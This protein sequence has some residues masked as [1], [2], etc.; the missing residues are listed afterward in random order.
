MGGNNS[1]M[2]NSIKVAQK[3]VN[4]SMVEVTTQ[5]TTEAKVVTSQHGDINITAFD[6]CSVNGIT[7]NQSIAGKS[8]LQAIFDKSGQT[9]ANFANDLKNKIQQN[10]EQEGDDPVTSAFNSFFGGGNK[11]IAQ[12]SDITNFVSNILQ[13]SFNTINSTSSTVSI[14]QNNAINIFC[15]DASKVENVEINNNSE[16]DV[17]VMATFSEK[18]INSS[19]FKNILQNELDQ[20]SE[21]KNF[22]STILPYIVMLAIVGVVA[23]LVRGKTKDQEDLYEDE[24]P[25]YPPTEPYDQIE[26]YPPTEPYPVPTV[27]YDPTVPPYNQTDQIEGGIMRNYR[28][29]RAKK[30]LEAYRGY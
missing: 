21:Q 5:N 14:E 27:T 1:S 29:N 6:N 9:T 24:I 7:L 10:A 26:Q 17:R 8:K 4:M 13:Q 12:A 3:I 28:L 22:W 30:R 16:Y 18:F 23:M 20:T 11:D 25:Q 19:D 15:A 2:T